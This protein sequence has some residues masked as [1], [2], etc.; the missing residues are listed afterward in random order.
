MKV[1]HQ[2]PPTV[3]KLYYWI[4]LLGVKRGEALEVARYLL[5]RDFESFK[6]LDD[7]DIRR[8][9]DAFEGYHLISTVLAQRPPERDQGAVARDRA[10]DPIPSVAHCPGRR[11]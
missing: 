11:G 7:H 2:Q 4:T 5:R 9:L 10:R 6:S 1:P 3:R 8:L